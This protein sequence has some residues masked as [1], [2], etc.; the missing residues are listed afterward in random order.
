MEKTN[1]SSKGL[2]MVVVGLWAGVILGAIII[3]ILVFTG[4][5]PLLG[6]STAQDSGEAPLAALESGTTIPDIEMVSLKG[7][8][9]RPSDYRG[10]VVLMNFWATWCGPCIREMPMFQEYQDRYPNLVVLGVDEEETPEK[11]SQFIEQMGIT[12]TIALDQ[13]AEMGR[14]MRVSFL[15]TTIFVDEKGEIRFRHYGI[16][17]E[18]QL[19]YYLSTLGVISE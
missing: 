14:A 8:P 3:G 2:V 12:Y 1:A 9:M 11:V 15:P 4:V 7:E 10:K 17:S 19:V 6:N 18:E 13:R 16:M 5:I